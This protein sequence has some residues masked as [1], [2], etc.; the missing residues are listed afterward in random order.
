[1]PIQSVLSTK[2]LSKEQKEF[3]TKAHIKVFDYD[4][5]DIEFTNFDTEIIVENAIITSQNA[6]KA[7]I[8]NKV[9]IK[10]CFCVGEKT[11]AFLE[12]NGQ[13]VSKMKLHAQDLAHHIVKYHKNDNFI[14][15]CSNQR[16]DALPEI[17]KEHHI[18][19]KEIIVYNTVEA[20]QK[21][22]TA[23]DAILFYSPSGINSYTSKNDIADKTAFCIGKTTAEEA[24]QHTNNIVT[25]PSPTI[26]HLLQTVVKYSKK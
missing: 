10:N 26:E 20:P 4:A 6:A 3:L 2:T 24:K 18:T 9:V 17:L 1:M 13:Y 15:F 22:E 14:Y 12:D 25:A 16:Q 19:L 5:I 23:Y 8:D 11:M 7:V 21:I